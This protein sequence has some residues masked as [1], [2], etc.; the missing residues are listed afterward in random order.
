[1]ITFGFKISDNTAE[2]KR[3]ADDAAYRNFGHAAASIRKD[4]MAS[5]LRPPGVSATA[6]L[7]RDKHG[8]FRHG[9]G[10]KRIHSLPSPPG[11][12][13]YSPSGRLKKS[14]AYAADKTG[15]VIGPMQSVVGEA[16]Q[17]M[18]FGG[19]FKRQNY[20]P[21]PFMFPALERALPRFAGDWAGSIG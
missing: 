15:A 17:P 8:R 2:V 9:S 12:P 6:G 4:A 14:I 11:Q 7:A 21:R 3:K 1:M 16:A 20:P 18:E 5:L 13:P 19:H 10:R